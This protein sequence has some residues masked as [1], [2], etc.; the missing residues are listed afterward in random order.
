MASKGAGKL[1]GGEAKTEGLALYFDRI[2]KGPE[3]D[4]TK[5]SKSVG[6]CRQVYCTN[7]WGAL[8]LFSDK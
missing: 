5:V 4:W 2:R 7:A 8:L 3:A 1:K 6:G